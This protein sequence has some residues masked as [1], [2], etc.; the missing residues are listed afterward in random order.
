MIRSLCVWL[1]LLVGCF[2]QSVSATSVVFLNPGGP[3]NPYWLSYSRFMQAAAERLGMRLDVRYSDRD[4]RVLLEQARDALQGVERPDY[5]VFSN[6]LN[7]APEIL[8][9]SRGSEV[10]LLAVNNTFTPAQRE[11]LGDL[12]TRYPKFLG[13]VVGNDEEGGYLTAKQLIE[14]GEP[15]APGTTVDLIA[16]SATAGT[17]V[18]LQRE[19]G[20][21]R[22]LAEHPEVRLR[23]IVLGG[24]R[25]D[26]AQE[27]AET[28][29]KRYP[30]T[31]L[32][33]AA[34]DSMAFGAMDA[35]REAGKV[36][37]KDVRV[38]AINGS[39]SALLAQLDG[40]LNIV[41]GQHFTLGGWALVVLHDY[42]QQAEASRERIG[43]R[44]VRVLEIIPRHDTLRYLELIQHDDLG[45]DV[46]QYLGGRSPPGL[47]SPFLPGR[48]D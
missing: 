48:G 30:D 41:A 8:R 28:L 42:E 10:R 14:Q 1:F 3:D 22:A 36:P 46:S 4:T 45:I 25:R 5:L 16:F 13:S 24:W 43:D 23:H 34:N 18:S 27:Q 19:Q 12:P 29:L 47:P 15:L 38:S 9:L 21:Y 31:R 44:T 11:M 35:I 17:P 2:A 7:V 39:L 6:E 33:W 20:L 32:V 40:S 37:G 26:R